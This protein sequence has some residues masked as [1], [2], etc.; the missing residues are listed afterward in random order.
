[1]L[2][3]LETARVAELGPAHG[4]DHAGADIVTKRHRAQE[5][6]PVNAKLLPCCESRG[7]DGAARMR[8]RGIVGI[9]GLIRVCHDAIGERGVARSSRERRADD[10]GSPFSGMR[11]GIAQRR[12]SG[13]QLRSRNHRCQR[14]EQM[15]LGVLGGLGGKHPVCRGAH[16][17]AECVHYRFGRGRLSKHTFLRGVTSHA[18]SRSYR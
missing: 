10:R 16:I 1:M 3:V 14:V 15:V 9:I 13:Q 12:L 2:W 6:R 5:P 8:A 4:H 17:G 11:G 7:H 18:S